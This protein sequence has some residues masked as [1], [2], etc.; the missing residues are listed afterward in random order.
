[1]LGK[2]K[3]VIV[4]LLLAYGIVVP[5]FAYAYFN[6]TEP[7]YVTAGIVLQT[8]TMKLGF[9]WDQSCSQPVTNFDFG[10]LA[11]PAQPIEMW[12][13]IWI[14]NEGDVWH[15]LTWNS[16]LSSVTNE[17]E[18]RWNYPGYWSGGGGVLYESWDATAIN[19]TTLG[20]GQVAETYYI[21]RVQAYPTFGTYN[22]TLT[23]WGEY[24][25]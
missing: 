20:P 3:V 18:E 14:R 11:H 21:I 5:V 4:S 19:G 17:I 16:T 6:Q 10:N 24:Y 15:A 23:A 22:W 2:K 12:K 9:Y 13:H 1:M 8:P 25:Y 7:T